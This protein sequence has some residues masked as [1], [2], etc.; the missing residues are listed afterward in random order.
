MAK[1][2][3]FA[4]QIHKGEFGDRD[5]EHTGPQCTSPLVLSAA[6]RS[7]ARPLAWDVSTSVGSVAQRWCP[8][9]RMP[10]DSAGRTS[11][12]LHYGVSL[13]IVMARSRSPPI[14]EWDL[15]LISEITH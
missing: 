10:S 13:G 5:S 1:G 15:N 3:T 4:K 8:G 11:A 14:Q 12:E 6:H 2:T 7:V 9:V